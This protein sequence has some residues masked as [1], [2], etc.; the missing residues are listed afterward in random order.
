MKKTVALLALFAFAAGAAF[1]QQVSISGMFEGRANFA[2]NSIHMAPGGAFIGAAS[3]GTNTWAVDRILDEGLR[4][5][6]AQQARIGLTAQNLDAT[7]GASVAAWV[8]PATN[9]GQ[10]GYQSGAWGGGTS[11]FH[12]WAWWRPR[13]S[14]RIM[15]GSQSWG[16]FGEAT[17]IVGWGFNANGSE[18][19][20]VGHGTAGGNHYGT[21]FMRG[22]GQALATGGY[23]NASVV[24]LGGGDRLHRITGFYGGFANPGISLDIRPMALPE[25]HVVFA[26]PLGTYPPTPNTLFLQNESWLASLMRAH[27]SVRYT[28][29]DVG[30]VFFS[31]IGGPGYWGNRDMPG[32]TQPIAQPSWN[33]NIDHGALIQGFSSGALTGPNA[34]NSPKFYL[35]F[36]TA[37]GLL[38]N[39]QLN[40]GV[41]YTLP[42]AIPD[43]STNRLPGP[44]AGTDLGPG[45]TFHFPVEFGL[46]AQYTSGD[47]A[48]RVRFAQTAFGFTCV[49]GPSV[50]RLGWDADRRLRHPPMTGFNISP[51]Y[52]LGLLRLHLNAG[53][54]ILWEHFNSRNPGNNYANV[55][56]NDGGNYGSSG[57]S[58][59]LGWHATPYVAMP[60]SNAWLFAGF[61]IETNGVR[62]DRPANP[63]TASRSDNTID[64]HWRIPVGMRI[65]F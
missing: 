29:T 2:S 4:R 24:G 8:F 6:F 48:I 45:M 64:I 58:G 65:E 53:V 7:F 22:R 39:L 21:G 3:D 60:I 55:G 51:S 28:L 43:D 52:N 30:T 33:A 37:H 41:A 12:G 42:F 18:D 1:A 49:S 56:Q 5:G 13:P 11:H 36:L 15:I 14:T 63:S 46:A 26:L 54:Q 20:L 34:T 10:W 31:V 17:A 23:A 16:H 47:F 40:V 57:W 50:Q 35:S 61:H 62:L 59:A 38:P 27:L 19:T 32:P 25:L 44:G 9:L